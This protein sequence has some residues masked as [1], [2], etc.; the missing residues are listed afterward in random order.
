MEYNLRRINSAKNPS[1]VWKIANN[2]TNPPVSSPS[3]SLME[4]DKEVVD[5][6]NVA[7][8]F[9]TFF[10]E[11][12]R[13]LR[14]G[15]DKTRI[16]DPL[17]R[18]KEKMKTSSA[19]FSLHTVTEQKV[20]K[21]ITKLKDKNSS[22]IDGINS[23]VLKAASRCLKV[24]LTYI[25][26][27]SISAGVFPKIWKRSVVKPLLK[28][29]DRKKKENYRPISLLPVSSKILEHVVKEQVA[30]FFEKNS[31]FPVNQ[32]GFRPKRSTC[33]ALL[34][35]Q[36]KLIEGHEE[37]KTSAA[38]LWDLSAAFD[39]IDHSILLKKLSIY[40]FDSNSISWF[41]SYLEDRTQIVQV[42][43]SFSKEIKITVGSPQG[44]VL[45]PLI[46]IIYGADLDLWL[47]NGM[48]VGFADD[49]TTIASDQD[50]EVMKSKMNEDN[51]S[52]LNFMNSNALI[53][54][55]KKSSLLVFR[56]GKCKSPNVGVKVGSVM[57]EESEHQKLLGITLSNNFSWSKHIS[58]LVTGLN[59]RIFMLKRLTYHLPAKNLTGVVHG[60]ILSK[61]RYGL[62]IYGQIRLSGNDPKSSELRPVEVALNSTMRTLTGNKIKD[63][64][65]IQSLH[66]ITSLPS[67][68]Q[69]TGMAIL[70]EV[71]KI[72]N[73]DSVALNN[74][75]HPIN[76]KV[77]TRS[78]ERGDL[79]TLGKSKVARKGFPYQGA[80]LWNECTPTIKNATSLKNAQTHIRRWVT[81]LPL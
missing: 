67:L 37:G 68:N 4:D 65:S 16:E 35:I 44:A 50:E 52:V 8:I 80:K 3:M 42:G 6:Q 72:Q 78:R 81:T 51:E 40:G 36:N 74:L 20:E 39:C 1:E 79:Q 66:E 13:A 33:T 21:L 46:F 48:A 22:G 31:L 62:P 75:M 64:K 24:P 76:H 23:K 60:L 5:D 57:V 28:R 2:I 7:E 53:V 77:S 63:K 71:W 61:I 38:L 14:E 32:H 58:E 55:E 47:V 49:T 10:V 54:N 41:K 25:V 59:N 30:R 69:M 70:Q 19:K 45:S 34:A 11:K 9:N 15:I 26:N 73:G 56:P 43:E 29:G 27:A 17:W 12:I 18:L